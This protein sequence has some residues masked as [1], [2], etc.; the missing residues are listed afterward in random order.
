MTFWYYMKGDR[1]GSLFV[2]LLTSSYGTIS[3][4]HVKSVETNDQWNYAQAGFY[5]SGSYEVLIEGMRGNGGSND[6][7]IAIDDVFFKE[8]SYC[9]VLPDSA[10][11]DYGMAL[12]RPTRKTTTPSPK[13][14][15]ET[16]SQP[17]VDT[18]YDC[19]FERDWCGWKQK[20]PVSFKKWLR[21]AANEEYY[22]HQPETDH[23]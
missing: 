12:T 5:W 23:T 21:I 9:K 10:K 3:I 1:P 16:S 11:I 18:T 6:S 4:W 8:S 2:L 22:S 15:N 17:A 13:A 20:D 7:M 14:S 19:D